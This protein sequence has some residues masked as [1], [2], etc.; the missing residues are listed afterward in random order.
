[1][2]YY[3]TFTKYIIYTISFS[4]ILIVYLINNQNIN[5]NIKEYINFNIYL[6]PFINCILN[7]ICSILLIIS[8][9]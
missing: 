4:V 9:I 3:D 5:C 8:F 6:I 2:K 1:M 7:T